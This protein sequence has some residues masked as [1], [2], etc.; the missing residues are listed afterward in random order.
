MKKQQTAVEWLEQEFVKLEQTIGVHDKMYEIIEQAKE[1][2]QQQIIDAFDNG[3][4]K[5]AELGFADGKNTTT[6]HTEMSLTKQVF[7]IIKKEGQL[8]SN[9]TRL[10]TGNRVAVAIYSLKNYYG[11]PV[12]SDYYQQGKYGH[13]KVYSLDYQN[14]TT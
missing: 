4:I 7:E 8:R 3:Y 12:R 13:Y 5:C 11:V 10:P 1:M 14:S 2:E 9:D 6:K